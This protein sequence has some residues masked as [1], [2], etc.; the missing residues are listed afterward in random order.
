[1]KKQPAHTEPKVQVEEAARTHRAECGPGQTAEPDFRESEAPE[2]EPEI[3][4]SV[5]QSDNGHADQG[6]E[7][8]LLGPE[9]GIGHHEQGV[10]RQQEEVEAQEDVGD[11]ADV[12][13][14]LEQDQEG[15]PEQEADPCQQEAGQEDHGQAQGDISFGPERLS[16]PQ[17]LTDGGHAPIGQGNGN[18]QKKEQGLGDHAQRGL[19]AIADLPGHIDVHKPDEEV[20][21][22][23]H[24]LRPGQ[25]P[26]RLDVRRIVSGGSSQRSLWLR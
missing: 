3:P 16:S 18:D 22:H 6:D 1:L 5:G 8:L 21:E 13:R 20:E 15:R 4:D 17:G 9:D 12:F 26:D 25:F 19:D 24:G 10:D 23:H 7:N 11:G 14:G 2:T